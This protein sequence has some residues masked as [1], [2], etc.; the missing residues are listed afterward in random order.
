MKK[1]KRTVDSIFKVPLS[2]NTQSYG[3]ILEK[4]SVAIFKIKVENTVVISDILK[5]DVLFIVAVYNS[6]ITTGRWEIIGTVKLDSRFATLPLNFI[7][8]SINPESFEIYNPN[9][10]EITKSSKENCLGLE[11]AAVWEAEHVESRIFDY[12]SGKENVWVKQLQIK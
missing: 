8:D 6:V 9:N 2:D 7:Q 1:Q 5:Q 3:I 10:G 11:C 12:F 4:S